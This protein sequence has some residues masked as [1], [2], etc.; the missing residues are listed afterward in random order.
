MCTGAK[1]LCQVKGVNQDSSF[2][3]FLC[4]CVSN[5]LDIG[6]SLSQA[7]K[8]I[9]QDI[10]VCL[11][12]LPCFCCWGLLLCLCALSQVQNNQSTTL[13]CLSVFVGFVQNMWMCEKGSV[14]WLSLSEPDISN[15]VLTFQSIWQ[16][17]SG[18]ETG[19]S[20]D[21]ARNGAKNCHN[22]SCEGLDRLGGTG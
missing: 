2:Q 21:E 10:P 3:V 8:L 17:F 22:D 16:T 4:A 13:S 9:C 15:E 14:K 7:V 20:R 1:W 6:K 5:R 18:T 11:L 12:S 19:W